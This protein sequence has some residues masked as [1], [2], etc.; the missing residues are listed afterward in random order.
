MRLFAV[1]GIVLGGI[2]WLKFDPQ[3]ARVLTREVSYVKQSALD[4]TCPPSGQSWFCHILVDMLYD[5]G[6]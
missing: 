5:T 1:A 2:L 6:R 3:S 4:Q